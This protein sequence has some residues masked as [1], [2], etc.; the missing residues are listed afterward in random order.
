MIPLVTPP[1]LLLLLGRQSVSLALEAT[2]TTAAE[3]QQGTRWSDLEV[4]DVSTHYVPFEDDAHKDWLEA[5]PGDD[6]SDEDPQWPDLDAEETQ[7]GYVVAE[8]AISQ[9][10]TWTP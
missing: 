6:K 8:P 1:L 10:R 5:A 9:V 7:K 4:E 3:A 2:A